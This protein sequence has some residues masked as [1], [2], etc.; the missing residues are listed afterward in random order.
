MTPTSRQKHM[1]LRTRTIDVIR[2][3]RDFAA[4]CSKKLNQAVP[5]SNHGASRAQSVLVSEKGRLC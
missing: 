1:S 5:S 4:G 3:R 2:H